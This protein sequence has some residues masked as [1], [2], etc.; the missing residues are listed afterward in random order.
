MGRVLA[1]LFGLALLLAGTL[2]AMALYSPGDDDAG[3]GGDAGPVP[4]L[5][6]PVEEGSFTG[7][8]G[9]PHDEADVFAFD[10]PG[11]LWI[12]LALHAERKVSLSLHRDGNPWTSLPHALL[13]E[14]EATTYLLPEEGPWYLALRLHDRG[15]PASAVVYSFDLALEA[16]AQVAML[17]SDAPWQTMEIVLSEPTRFV[18]T[19]RATLASSPSSQPSVLMALEQ[20]DLRFPD[21]Q[22][23]RTSATLL[24][25]SGGGDGV[26]VAPVGLHQ[27][28][29]L[30][31]SPLAEASRVLVGD[32]GVLHAIDLVT[33]GPPVEGALRLASADVARG[34]AVLLAFS[35]DRPFEVRSAAGAEVVLWSSHD[36]GAAVGVALPGASVVGP[37]DLVLEVEGLAFGAFL[38]GWH[39]GTFRSPEGQTVALDHLDAAF[40]LGAA[41]GSWEFHLG[42]T[43]GVGPSASPPYLF[44]AEVPALGLVPLWRD[45][46][47]VW[48]FLELPA[49]L[50]SPGLVPGPFE[51]SPGKALHLAGQG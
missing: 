20:F 9:F 45:G 37:R 24:A 27:T 8:L 12:H 21:R 7:R 15:T 44:L 6:V 39:E 4:A 41:E 16:P 49:S 48:R 51:A 14:G 34:G 33:A 40:F 13:F 2:N 36:S 30:P 18:L 42:T 22:Y 25:A 35:A 11:G 29:G 19:T 5:A 38:P 28:L 10:A 47:N 17:R 46:V 50:P 3:S 26:S 31:G 23:H 32:E 43:A 1:L